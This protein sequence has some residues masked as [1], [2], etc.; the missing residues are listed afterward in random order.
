MDYQV[1]LSR[2]ARSDI[3]DIVRYISIDDPDQALRFGR[4]LYRLNHTERS[5]E[6]I[7]FGT[8]REAY[9]T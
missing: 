9:L 5:V 2:S 8:R 6:V 4:F 3:K 7:R 1:K